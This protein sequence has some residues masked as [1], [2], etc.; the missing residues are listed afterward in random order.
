MYKKALALFDQIGGRAGLVRTQLHYAQ[1][2]AQQGQPDEA[3]KMEQQARSDSE[4]IG[5]YLL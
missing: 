2:L 5:L 4:V 3:A 1:F